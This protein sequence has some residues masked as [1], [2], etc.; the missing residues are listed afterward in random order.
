MKISLNW[1]SDFIDWKEK[2]PQ[3]IADRLTAATGEV[4]DIVKQG[5]LLDNIVVGKITA[6]KK[7][8]NADK[9]SL[10]DVE[11]DKGTKHVVCG[12]T[13]LKDGMLVAFAHVGANVKWQG[14]EMMTLTAVKIRGEQSEGMICAAEEIDLET[15]FPPSP[16]D[17]SK[18]IVDLTGKVTA[19]P[20]TPLREALGLNDVILHID[21]HAI[22]NRPDLFSHIGF[23]RECVALGLGTWKKKPEAKKLPFPK[24]ALP[25][26]FITEAPEL[27]PFYRACLIK[28]ENVGT[29]PDWMKQR[30]EAT[31][32]RTINLPIDI[33][34]YV[35][36]EVGVPLHSFDADDIKGDIH[37]RTAKEGETIVTLDKSEHTL[38]EGALVL[39]DDEGIFDLM[40][41]MGGLRSSTKDSTKH[42]Y[43]HSTSVDGT[44]IRRTVIA[45]GHRT[46]AATVYEKGVPPV[47]S[48][49]GFLRAAE[50]FLELVPGAKLASKMEAQGTIETPAPISLSLQRLNSA[51]GTNLK[52]EEVTTILNALE[53]KT[54]TD[55]EPAAEPLMEAT[56]EPTVKATKEKVPVKKRKPP[57]RHS[58]HASTLTVTPPPHRIGDIAGEHDL[59][60]EVAR[61]YGY[62]AIEPALPLAPMQLPP[63]DQR[64]N[65]LRDALKERAYTELIHLAFMRPDLF[66]KCGLDKNE[67]VV[68]ENPLGEEVSRMRISLLPQI[69][70][71]AARQLKEEKDDLLLFETGHVFKKGEEKN[72]FCAA[73]ATKGKA[74]LGE[75]PVLW[76]KADLLSALDEV[77]YAVTF[78]Q[79]TEGLPAYAHSGRSADILY[80]DTVV[81][82][83]FDMHPSVI[84]AMDLPGR[85]A[86]IILDWEK[87]ADMAPAIVLE[88]KLPAFP[89]ISYDETIPLPAKPVEQMLTFLKTQSPLLESVRVID[90]YDNGTDKRLTVRFVYRAADRT[91]EQKETD[92]VHA[93]VL[94]T[95]RKE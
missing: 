94:S 61:I 58:P 53:F 7:H 27:M 70:E 39:S 11:T 62:G 74:S 67:A 1:L 90:L 40:A 81:G 3:V 50:L 45:T 52:T 14:G 57:V 79:K 83:L 5:A 18:P 24:T 76:M 29:T 41:I 87:L 12:G 34:N 2:N 38:P 51:L 60:E 85:T 33:T 26:N 49:Q 23:A 36:M 19:A 78:R 63:R 89:P 95:I 72:Q 64:L 77:G 69:L 35:M 48:E 13:N 86:A 16:E 43:L 75:E 65:Q 88:S 47:T 80:H 10:C 21:N 73:I 68:L 31:G 30:L 55:A 17:G 46:D 22:T 8:P 56:V 28:I 71:T 15:Q 42:I 82:L 59:F 93:K 84:K 54:D 66:A 44:N 6:L 25:F 37:A 9:L 91:L 32:W 20:G 4:D 92:G